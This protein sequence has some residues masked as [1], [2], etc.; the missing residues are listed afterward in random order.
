MST[1]LRIA[2]ARWFALLAIVAGLALPGSWLLIRNS[3]MSPAGMSSQTPVARASHK[4]YATPAPAAAIAQTETLEAL[5]ARDPIAFLDM[6]VQRYDRS[7]RDYTCTFSK[8]ESINGRLG[9]NQVIKTMFRE[10][11]FSVRM[12]WIKNQDKCA[13]VLYVA[14]QWIKD[15]EQ[16]ALV[17]PG[18]IA[19]LLVPYVMRP[20]RGHDARKSSRKMI[21]QFGARN[22]LLMT[23][24]YCKLAKE[25]NVLR[26][27]YKGVREVDG[28]ETLLFE[29]HLP[30]TTEGGTWPD[31]VLEVYMDKQLLLPVLCVAYADDA[32]QKLLGRYQLSD[33]KLNVNLP[34]SVFTKEGMGLR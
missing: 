23:L 22:S 12:E 34:D 4:A 24:Q 17:E 13:R 28:S 16:M 20:I 32:K 14:D 8:Q 29:R 1:M 25:Q 7:V 11:P 2:K 33:I 19:R 26:L 15:G 18:P 3:E 10:S 9:A 5:A 6:A 30:Y 27:E 31:R 21:D